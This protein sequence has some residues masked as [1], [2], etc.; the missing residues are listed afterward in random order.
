MEKFVN[1]SFRNCDWSSNKQ[2]V[3]DLEHQRQI[4]QIEERMAKTDHTQSTMIHHYYTD[5]L[6]LMKKERRFFS[7]KSLKTITNWAILQQ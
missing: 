1:H 2:F 7:K 5:L 6:Q 3:N 4:M